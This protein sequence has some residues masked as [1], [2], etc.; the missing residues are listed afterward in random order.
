MR[1]FSIAILGT[2]LLSLFGVQEADAAGHRMQSQAPI[3]TTA[4]AIRPS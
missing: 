2:F 1:T 3:V 4:S